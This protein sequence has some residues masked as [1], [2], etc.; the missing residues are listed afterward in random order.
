MNVTPMLQARQVSVR[1]G[2]F[3]ALDGVDVSFATGRITGLIGPNGAGKSTLLN[4][5]GGSVRQDRGDVRLHGRS[6]ATTPVHERARQGLTRSF[7]I[8]RELGSLTVLEN[9]LLAGRPQRDGVV[10]ALFRPRR[11]RACE[12]AMI[13]KARELLVRVR[14]W[15]LA[16][17]P[18]ER[19]SGG[20]KKLLELVRA[21]FARPKVVLLD[22]PAAGVNP[23][24]VDELAE[25]I[26]SINRHDGI[27]FGIVEHNM[28]MIAALCDHVYVLAAGRVLSEGSYA[29]VAAHPAVAEA[30]LGAIH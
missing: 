26:R 23:Q 3:Q 20:Q 29:E 2:G 28:D 5:L 18:A 4:V 14:L 24:L 12:E 9:V 19:L 27:T 10:D 30:Y 11:T 16:D 17:A 21:L 22:E 25:H 1:F 7:Q 15:P 8:T 13:E 6:I